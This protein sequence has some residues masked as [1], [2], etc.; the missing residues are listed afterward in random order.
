MKVLLLASQTNAFGEVKKVSNVANVVS[1]SGSF[2]LTTTC[3]DTD[4]TVGSGGNLTTA[5]DWTYKT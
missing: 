2:L 3:E 4:L 5:D 1:F